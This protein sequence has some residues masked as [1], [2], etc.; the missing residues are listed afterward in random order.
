MVFVVVVD[1]VV[2]ELAM[3]VVALLMVVGVV[4]DLMVLWCL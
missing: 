2:I 4:V 1:R 3:V